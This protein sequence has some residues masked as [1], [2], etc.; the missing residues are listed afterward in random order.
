MNIIFYCFYG[1]D[2]LQKYEFQVEYVDEIKGYDGE[3]MQIFI[4][5]GRTFMTARPIRFVAKPLAL[6]GNRC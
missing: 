6:T 4:K 3:R 1:T 5:D 2:I